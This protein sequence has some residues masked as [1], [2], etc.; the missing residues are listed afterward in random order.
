MIGKVL[1]N[2]TV[3]EYWNYGVILAIYISTQQVR[4]PSGCCL[5]GGGPEGCW[6]AR[7]IVKARG[8]IYSVFH[9]SLIGIRPLVSEPLGHFGILKGF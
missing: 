1:W 3:P 9:V 4:E 5:F 7:F 8:P 2:S 6:F